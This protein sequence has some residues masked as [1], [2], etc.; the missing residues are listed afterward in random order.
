M[1]GN[2]YWDLIGPEDGATPG[3]SNKPTGASANPYWD[4]IPALPPEQ[5]SA[6]ESF[7]RGGVQ[8]ASFGGSDELVGAAKAIGV[9][10]VELAQA[11]AEGPAGLGSYLGTKL[12]ITF[13]T[14]KPSEVVKTYRQGRDEEHAKNKAANDAHPGYYLGGQ[15][16]GGIAG[17][18]AAA[19]ASVPGIVA[20]GTAAGG[21][22]AL[23][24]S[25]AD[26]TR[27]EF[28]KAA[29]DVG[30][31]M[32]YGGG[33]AVGGAAVGR[34]AEAL[35]G[36]TTRISKNKM[37]AALGKYLE[38]IVTR[39]GDPA[40]AKKA[41]GMLM[42]KGIEAAGDA[43]IPTSKLTAL[44]DDFAKLP[45][46]RRNRIVDDAIDTAGR[47]EKEGATLAELDAELKHWGNLASDL[48]AADPTA[49]RH[50]LMVKKAIK[51]EIASLSPDLAG[52]A[53]YLSGRADYAKASAAGNA[54][55]KLRGAVD[56]MSKGGE[57][58]DPKKFASLN[59]GSK[60]KQMEAWLS[61]DPEA[62]RAWRMGAEA[63][64]V[65]ARKG[66]RWI[67]KVIR[68]QLPEPALKA[69]ENVMR[70]FDVTRVFTDPDLAKDFARAVLPGRPIGTEAAVNLVSRL[71]ARLSMDER[72]AA[73]L[74]AVAAD[75]ADHINPKPKRRKVAQAQPGGSFVVDPAN[76]ASAQFQAD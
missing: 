44:R 28:E 34:T 52:A 40:E 74:K 1:A 55:E 56:S 38:G 67:P 57:A 21:L 53:E 45:A 54:L 2:P 5:P 65:L 42:Q 35:R 37:V 36:I 31:G 19:P 8:G 33:L 50:A 51:E 68:D 73:T 47:F 12:G 13:G 62:L 66:E 3:P 46:N 29:K 32:L 23:G 7:V 75:A 49:A 17:G 59:S 43:K 27:G 58:L 18:V 9:H 41:A 15:I 76:L 30:K 6:A 72:S 24:D 10:P 64:R 22:G 20:A 16:A 11:A 63:A 26:L 70:S 39:G 71:A 48:R 4:L 60:K 61:D 14:K 25:E 69:A